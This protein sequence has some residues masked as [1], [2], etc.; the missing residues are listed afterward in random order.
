MSNVS[1]NTMYV[2]IFFL[3]ADLVAAVAAGSRLRLCKSLL[4]AH[5]LV[6][7]ATHSRSSER[8]LLA[9]KKERKKVEK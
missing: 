2:I 6:P 8:H 7:G 3:A 5:G 4:G 1:N 9:S